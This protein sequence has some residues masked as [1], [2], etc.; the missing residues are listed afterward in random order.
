MEESQSNCVLHCGMPAL[1][2]KHSYRTQ[3]YPQPSLIASLPGDEAT[4][5]HVA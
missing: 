1:L 4:H 3:N 5:C 2:L